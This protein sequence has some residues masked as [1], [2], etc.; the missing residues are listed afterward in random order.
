MFD[1][2]WAQTET[3]ENSESDGMVYRTDVS[4]MGSN[5]A[6]LWQDAGDGGSGAAS[7]KFRGRSHCLKVPKFEGSSRW[8]TD[9]WA[10]EVP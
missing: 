8:K 1:R 10:P 2:K 3:P 5:G 9:P 6:L 7:G 4:D